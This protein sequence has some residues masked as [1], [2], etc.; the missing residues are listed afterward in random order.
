MG[1]LIESALNKAGEVTK[2]VGNE[3]NVQVTTEKKKKRVKYEFCS[4]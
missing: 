3:P 1:D 2:D 4:P